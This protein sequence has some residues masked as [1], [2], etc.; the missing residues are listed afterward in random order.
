MPNSIDSIRTNTAR[1]ASSEPTWSKIL[2]DLK[3]WVE[4]P[5]QGQYPKEYRGTAYD[6]IIECF[7]DPSRK[8]LILRSLG[9]TVAPPHFPPNVEIV[10]LSG[11]R[12]RECST[13]R[14]KYLKDVILNGNPIGLAVE[15]SNRTSAAKLVSK[16]TV[17]KNTSPKSVSVPSLK[18]SPSFVVAEPRMEVTRPRIER[19]ASFVVAKPRKDVARPNVAPS[20]M[21]YAS[22][23]S[24]AATSKPM[25][26]PEKKGANRAAAA[27]RKPVLNR[28]PSFV[29]PKPSKGVTRPKIERSATFLLGESRKELPRPNAASV[30]VQ[31][32]KKS[33]TAERHPK[34]LTG[35]SAK[36]PARAVFNGF[37]LP[38]R[39]KEQSAQRFAARFGVS[40]RAVD[41]PQPATLRPTR[42]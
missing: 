4:A 20:D 18:R 8:R 17:T 41:T 39:T 40:A 21:Q 10:D 32:L 36:Q 38:P 26:K 6:K 2:K 29:V 24:V 31:P 22:Q 14:S 1:A 3:T 9:L 30:D 7:N 27:E 42:S 25:A 12:L 11:N 19:S 5:G 15:T 37:D 13:P 16:K 23:Q 35:E 34:I 33:A 28:S